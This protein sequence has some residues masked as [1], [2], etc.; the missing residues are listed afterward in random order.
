M[1]ERC[2]R[3][4]PGLVRRREAEVALAQQCEDR[5]PKKPTAKPA[6]ISLVNAAQY[7]DALPHQIRAFEWLEGL[8]TT[9]ELEQFGAMYR[10]DE[11]VP[12]ILDVPYYYQ[13]DSVTPQG[14]RMCF[15]STCSMAVEYLEP[16]T[17]SA[18]T[19]DDEYLARVEKYGDTTDAAAQVA[20]MK[21][22]GIDCEF[23]TDGTFQDIEDQLAKG[24][25]VPCGW[26]QKGPVTDPTGG[27]H[28]SLVVGTEGENLVVHDPFGEAAL[29]SGG[30][31]SQAM[32]AGQFVR[33]SRKNFGPRWEVEGPG[34]GWMIRIL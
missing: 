20:A 2:Q 1:G 21:S 10:D 14:F 8:L 17:L 11:E 31:V 32:T 28:W 9:E 3:P 16:G 22:Y 26:L 34:T 15:S 7:Y 23:I 6:P 5:A 29:V 19:G 33:Y 25:P 12:S 27:G 18:T 30:Y 4:S 13:L 24:L